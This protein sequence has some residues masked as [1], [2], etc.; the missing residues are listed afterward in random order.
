MTCVRSIKFYYF[1]VL[2]RNPYYG[3]VVSMYFLFLSRARSRAGLLVSMA[4]VSVLIIVKYLI[5]CKLRS[6]DTYSCPSCSQG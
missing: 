3:T 5:L 1:P 2:I 4:S 6:E